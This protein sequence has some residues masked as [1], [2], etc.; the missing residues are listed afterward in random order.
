[1]QSAVSRFA[2]DREKHGVAAFEAIAVVTT[3]LVLPIALYVGH[4]AEYGRILYPAANVL[5]AYYLFQRR[6]PWYAGHCL[7]LFCCVSLARRLV[8]E[9]AGWDPSNPILLTPYLCCLATVASFFKYWSQRSPVHIGTFVV[10]LAC[11]A[12]GVVLAML[13]GRMLAS[14]V[15]AL[16]WSVGPL[17]AVYVLANRERLP[18]IRNVIEPCL[19][20]AGTAMSVYGIAQFLDPPSWDAYWMRN[21]LEL[22]LNTIGRPE[23]FAV[24][25]FSTMNSP[26]SFGIVLTAAIVVA[27]KRSLPVTSLTVPL[28]LLG[29]A[30]CQYRSI[31]AATAIAVAMVLMFSRGG[32]V[33]PANI[34]ALAIIGFALSSIV[35]VPR[36]QETIVHRATSLTKLGGDASL[37]S[38]LHQYAALA[39]ADELVA[40]EG[41]AISGIS[42]R[43]DRQLPKEMDGAFIEIWR[44]M[45][46][47]VGTLFLLSLATF[48][49]SL[50]SYSPASGPHL[51]FDRA[52]VVSTLVQLPIGSV[53]I[54][55]LGFCAWMFIGFGLAARMN[56]SQQ[57]ISRPPAASRGQDRFSTHA[58][59][60]PLNEA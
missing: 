30:L 53:H 39:R 59:S 29:L 31:W 7:L 23:P 36:I 37:E 21:V 9:Q 27:L 4:V 19:I 12:Y 14:M 1:M 46:V 26:G 8:D 28:M 2:F 60:R 34:I 54:G 56:G 3:V 44:S 32:G 6:S 45:G 57:S 13:N 42:R 55:E 51:F 41:L 22:G 40:G 35:A 33:R 38:R 47:I 18:E 50:F 20:W 10:L 52:I 15:D 16:K 48:V 5:L 43:L 17:F 11:I 24:R 49:A 58:L 25:V